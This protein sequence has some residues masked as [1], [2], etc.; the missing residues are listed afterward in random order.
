MPEPNARRSYHEV[1]VTNDLRSKDRTDSLV[2]FINKHI[3]D[4]KG[5]TEE[6]YPIPKMLFERADLANSFADEI[7]KHLDI[8]REHIEVKAQK[9]DSKKLRAEKSQ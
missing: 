1:H 2:T 4:Y 5:K 6:S 3:G 8:P 9:G 7:S